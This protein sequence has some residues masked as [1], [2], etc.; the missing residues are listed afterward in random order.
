MTSQDRPGH[1]GR[2]VLLIE[3]N[4]DGRESLRALLTLAGFQVETAE[5]GLQGVKKALSWRPDTAIV[6]IGLPILDGYQVASCLREALGTGEIG[7]ILVEP[8]QGRGGEIFPPREFL[9]LLRRLA[10]EFGPEWTVRLK[11]LG[12]ARA[13]WRSQGLSPNE[14]SQHVRELIARMGWL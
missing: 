12:V 6:D 14:V 2:R 7:C 10:D 5:D 3:D 8:A 11:E 13:K 9:P 4:P 1:L